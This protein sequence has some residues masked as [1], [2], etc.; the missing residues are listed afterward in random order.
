MDN[1]HVTKAK[2]CQE[3]IM[4]ERLDSNSNF[5][6]I[7]KNYIDTLTKFKQAISYTTVY[8]KDNIMGGGPMTPVINSEAQKSS[9]HNLEQLIQAPSEPELIQS[10]PIEV[11]PDKIH[12]VPLAI[13]EAQLEKYMETYLS[14][15]PE[16]IKKSF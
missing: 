6:A 12:F 9:V 2:A 15:V 7:E 8:T 5:T 16:H 1:S 11:H 10:H 13:E 14:T 3:M 4:Y